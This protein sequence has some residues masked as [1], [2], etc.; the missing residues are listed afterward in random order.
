[1]SRIFTSNLWAQSPQK[2]LLHAS[3]PRNPRDHNP[4]NRGMPRS[5]GFFWWT[6]YIMMLPLYAGI[7]LQDVPRARS[8]HTVENPRQSSA[9]FEMLP[10]WRLGGSALGKG[11]QSLW[12]S[13]WKIC[14]FSLISMTAHTMHD[15]RVTHISTLTPG[16]HKTFAV[17]RLGT[18]W[19]LR[20]PCPVA[21]LQKQRQYNYGS[22]LA[23]S[24]ACVSRPSSTFRP[25]FKTPPSDHL[26]GA[27]TPDLRQCDYSID[28]PIVLSTFGRAT[29]DWCLSTYWFSLSSQLYRCPSCCPKRSFK[30]LTI[31]ARW[32]WMWSICSHAPV[33]LIRVSYFM[34]TDTDIA[35]RRRQ[36]SIVRNAYASSSKY[37]VWCFPAMLISSIDI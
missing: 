26:Y 3:L 10:F 9:T 21:Q 14:M 2:R 7:C 29:N 8:R 36:I 17:R 34:H 15:I 22:K 16:T 27:I 30:L 33:P 18:I 12:Q 31:V 23:P 20:A 1:M 19:L 4:N 5:H 13:L 11:P 6:F 35:R 24:A 25:A 28:A 32:F 37:L